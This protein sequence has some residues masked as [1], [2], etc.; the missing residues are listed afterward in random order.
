M[1]IQC[2]YDNANTMQIDTHNTLLIFTK[3]QHLLGQHNKLL[4]CR[5]IGDYKHKEFLKKMLWEWIETK[6]RLQ[7][8]NPNVNHISLLYYKSFS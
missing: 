5:T 8:G 2:T 4:R 1:H 3:V 7:T 6:K